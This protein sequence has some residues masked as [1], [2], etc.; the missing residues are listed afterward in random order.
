[1]QAITKRLKQFKREKH[2]I[3]TVIVVMLS[4]VLITIIVGNVVLWSYQMNQVDLDRMHETVTITGVSEY[5][6]GTRM[7]LENTGS[8]SLHVVAVWV[9]NSTTHQRYDADLF[10]NSGESITY[11]RADIEFPKDDFV[12][13]I[14]T[15]RGNMAVF[16]VD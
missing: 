9:S 1:L 4:L 14:V 12:A 11:N 3:S 8:L 13:K 10:L 5:E 16:S 15:D 7:D 2:G 6:S